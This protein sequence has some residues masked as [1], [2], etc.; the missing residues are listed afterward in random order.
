M[1]R[2]RASCGF[3]VVSLFVNPAQFN[4]SA[5]LA[6]YPRDEARDAAMARAEQADVLFIPAA[7]ELYP[8]AFATTV[9]VAELSDLLDGA[10]RGP[11]HFRGVTTV[12]A[13]LFNIV[14]PD[15]AFFGPEGRPASRDC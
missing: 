14:Q 4:D 11:A 5:D 9:A 6:A 2:A 12:V 1:R 7:E 15:V 8:A 13:K 10:F 3:V